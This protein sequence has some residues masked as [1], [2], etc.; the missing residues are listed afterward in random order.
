MQPS[1]T[2]LYFL[3]ILVL[4]LSSLKQA[5]HANPDAEKKWAGSSSYISIHLFLK[6]SS[7]NLQAI[8]YHFE[9]TDNDIDLGF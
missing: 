5:C 9:H 6:F 4:L 1:L 7:I 3:I 8:M 2:Y